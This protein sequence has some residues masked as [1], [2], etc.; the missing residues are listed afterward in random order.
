[1]LS[2]GES[3]QPTPVWAA[4]WYAR[5]TPAVHSPSAAPR[6]RNGRGVICFHPG[7]LANLSSA[8]ANAGERQLSLERSAKCGLTTLRRTAF[9]SGRQSAANSGQC[10]VFQRQ[11]WHNPCDLPF[12][13]ASFAVADGVRSSPQATPTLAVRRKLRR[14]ALGELAACALAVILL[15]ALDAKVVLVPTDAELALPK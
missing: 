10:S 4:Y 15:T 11:I 9:A 3:L 5:Q 1:M 7:H 8:L 14:P 2:L 12:R 13:K 6:L